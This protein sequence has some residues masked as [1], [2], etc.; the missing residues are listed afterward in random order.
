MQLGKVM[1]IKWLYVSGSQSEQHVWHRYCCQL[2]YTLAN[3]THLCSIVV[4]DMS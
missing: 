2:Y 1:G 3:K 4:I